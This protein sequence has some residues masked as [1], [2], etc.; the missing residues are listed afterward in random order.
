MT[1]HITHTNDE[2]AKSKQQHK[3]DVALWGMAWHRESMLS[4]S[5]TTSAYV[6]CTVRMGIMA[7]A[8]SANFT[9]D[10]IIIIFAAV[11]FCMNSN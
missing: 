10:I 8:T 9:A 5:S 2:T 3:S 4:S 7:M 1:W 6:V 11:F